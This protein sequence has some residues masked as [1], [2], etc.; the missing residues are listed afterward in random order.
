MSPGANEKKIDIF[1]TENDVIC[2]ISSP[3]HQPVW[4]AGAGR[5]RP[6]PAGSDWRRLGAVDA[7]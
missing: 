3:Q 4:V 7:R 2:R 5:C 6:V 1:A